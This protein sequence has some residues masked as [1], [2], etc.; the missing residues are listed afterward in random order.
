M[1]LMQ[2]S[3]ASWDLAP[4]LMASYTQGF[5]PHTI[6]DGCGLARRRRCQ[7]YLATAISSISSSSLLKS[8]MISLVV[9][10]AGQHGCLNRPSRWATLGWRASWRR[11]SLVNSKTDELSLL[12]HHQRW[13][14]LCCECY[15]K[16]ACFEPCRNILDLMLFKVLYP[17]T[18]YTEDG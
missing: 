18:N 7:K 17:L 2:P 13:S 10:K 5:D 4:V 1:H 11:N 8:P 6:A 16:S 15:P 3:C 12:D 14:T 9:F